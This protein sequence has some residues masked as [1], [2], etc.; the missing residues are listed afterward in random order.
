MCVDSSDAVMMVS[1][2]LAASQ[3]EMR[4]WSSGAEIQA[5]QL[6]VTVR[7][8]HTPSHSV[9]IVC[10]GPTDKRRRLFFLQ[11]TLVLFFFY[12]S[13]FSSTKTTTKFVVDETILI[14]VDGTKIAT[15]HSLSNFVNVTKTTTKIS[16]LSTR[17]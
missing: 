2:E 1:T 14:L 8:H 9:T 3:C 13:V 17:R 15:I 16:E 10:H 4:E 12:I 6:I 11:V 7:L 5:D